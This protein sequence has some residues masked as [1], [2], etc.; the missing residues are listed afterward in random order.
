MS[1][2]CRIHVFPLLVTL[3]G[4]FA[5]AAPVLGICL[6]GLVK[7]VWNNGPPELGFVSCPSG[8]GGGTSAGQWLALSLA[9]F[10]HTCLSTVQSWAKCLLGALIGCQR[11]LL[12]VLVFN[13][14]PEQWYK[15]AKEFKQYRKIETRKLSSILSDKS[16]LLN[17]IPFPAPH[18]NP[19]LCIFFLKKLVKDV[20]LE[21]FSESYLWKS[22]HGPQ[23]QTSFLLLHI[24]P[25]KR[26]GCL[27]R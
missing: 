15:L 24:S 18:K 8:G 20:A 16:Q 17:P 4:P 21:F 22:S 14:E 9:P 2:P 7:Q 26:A 5:Q 13:V 11:H 3:N 27:G 1:S 10:L 23:I 19:I 6:L 12:L 25:Q